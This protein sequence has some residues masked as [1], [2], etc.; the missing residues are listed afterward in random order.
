MNQEIYVVI[1]GW[2]GFTACQI[3]W[4]LTHKNIISTNHNN[5]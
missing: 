5:P 4:I 2:F 1:Q 3:C